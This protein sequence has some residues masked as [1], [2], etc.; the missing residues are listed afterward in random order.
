MNET[1]ARIEQLL[2]DAYT[3]ERPAPGVANEVAARLENHRHPSRHAIGRWLWP[4]LIAAAVLLA[5]ALGRRDD[6]NAPADPLAD[7]P[8][9]AKEAGAFVGVRVAEGRLRIQ[10]MAP[11]KPWTRVTLNGLAEYLKGAAKQHGQLPKIGPKVSPLRVVIRADRLTPW[12]HAQWIMMVCAE[13]KLYRVE[14]AVGDGK[15]VP[16][17]LPLDLDVGARVGPGRARMGVIVETNAMGQTAYG[18]RRVADDPRIDGVDEVFVLTAGDERAALRKL[19]DQLTAVD[20]K[21]LAAIVEIKAAQTVPFGVVGR[22]AAGIREA[23][24]RRIEFYG[25]AL[26]NAKQ[27]AAK[28]LPEPKDGWKRVILPD[29]DPIKAGDADEARALALLKQLRDPNEAAPAR[30]AAADLLIAMVHSK[31]S[32]PAR[33]AAFKGLVRALPDTSPTA[34]AVILR[35]IRDRLRD[36]GLLRVLVHF[37]EPNESSPPSVRVAAVEALRRSVGEAAMPWIYARRDD[38]DPDVRKAVGAALVRLLPRSAPDGT[39]SSM[40]RSER[41]AAAI[42]RA[43]ARTKTLS[44]ALEPSN[45]AARPIVALLRDDKLPFVAWRAACE[46]LRANLKEFPV[47][48]KGEVRPEDRARIKAAFAK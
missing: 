40:A 43:L 39:W 24:Y 34:T 2:R 47:A 38:P 5:V 15:P 3:D 12:L 7:K 45:L 18:V 48:I 10:R 1:N 20:T 29:P 26:P 46:W 27:R 22:L 17:P 11:G 21:R 14:L 6:D 13:Q 36:E 33:R 31:A 42:A 28:E 32:Q 44:L 37:L 19:K 9:P 4:G 41:G 23:G 30:L 8:G 25:T 35:F 16:T